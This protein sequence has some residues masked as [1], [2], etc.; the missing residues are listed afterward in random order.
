MQLSGATAQAEVELA[1]ARYYTPMWTS[2]TDSRKWPQQQRL[3]SI[4]ASKPAAVERCGSI[5]RDSAI[6]GMLLSCECC[7]SAHLANDD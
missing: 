6:L 5:T 1:H 7:W 2:S 3:D 4:A